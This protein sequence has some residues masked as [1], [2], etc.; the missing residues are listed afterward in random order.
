VSKTFNR[1][2]S[3][4]PDTLTCLFFVGLWVM[5]MQFGSQSVANG[6]LIMLVEFILVH[7]S[8]FL[9]GML[10][11]GAASR[12]KIV[13]LLLG[14]GLFYLVFIAAWSWAF[15]QWWPFFAFG[16]L[17]VGKFSHAM[18]PELS[19]ASRKQTMRSDWVTAGIAYVFGVFITSILPV[20]EFGINSSVV[21][22]LHLPGSGV[23]VDEPQRVIAFGALYFGL[24]AWSKSK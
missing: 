13:A 17:L 22:Q 14:F 18:K 8:G 12:R 11:D 3:A 6:M 1:L 9:G 19:S 23:W 24:L 2:L 7:A 10:L 21:A 4:L 5:P 20:P 15:Q 16:W